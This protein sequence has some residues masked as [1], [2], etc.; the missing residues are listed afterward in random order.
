MTTD[1]E[2]MPS[3]CL[4]NCTQVFR[5]NGLMNGR[6]NHILSG[7]G[8]LNDS[9][10]YPARRKRPPGVEECPPHTLHFPALA[11]KEKLS[12]KPQVNPVF[13]PSGFTT[14]RRPHLEH[15]SRHDPQVPFERPQNTRNLRLSTDNSF[16]R[17]KITF[18]SHS[19]IK[20]FHLIIR[21][22][23]RRK[24]PFDVFTCSQNP[25]S[26]LH[27]P[28]TPGTLFSSVVHCS[29]HPPCVD[30]R[31]FCH[32]LLPLHSHDR[33]YLDSYGPLYRHFLSHLPWKPSS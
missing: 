11:S 6:D 13:H 23:R 4:G 12:K 7:T 31:K 33:P 10:G 14:R 18:V 26:P 5:T 17:L 24:F 29:V 32:R 22:P 21:Q 15:F 1:R 28:D 2:E 16:S 27:I 3:I 9:T 8:C 20:G 30:G 25:G 19:R